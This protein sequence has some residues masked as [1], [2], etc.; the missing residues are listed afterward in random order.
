MVDGVLIL[1]DPEAHARFLASLSESIQKGTSSGIQ[2]VHRGEEE[3]PV[4][5]T[6][7]DSKI[8]GLA[9]IFVR[10]PWWVDDTDAQ[11]L[12][13]LFKTTRRETQLALHISCG[14]SLRQF[15]AENHL[16]MN[17]VKTHLRQVFKKTKVKSQMQLVAVVLAALR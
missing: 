10:D 16:A 11:T 17:T 5:L 4:F 13:A 3:P 1:R 9:G 2:V 8:Q 6:V 12:A 15:C 7:F 14:N